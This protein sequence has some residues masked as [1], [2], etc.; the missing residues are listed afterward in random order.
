MVFISLGSPENANAGVAPPNEGKEQGG[1]DHV[2]RGH[3]IND[4]VVS[5]SNDKGARGGKGKGRAVIK[6]K[7]GRLEKQDSNVREQQ[8]SGSMTV[9]VGPSR[10]R[11]VAESDNHANAD[12]APK[13]D[14]VPEPLNPSPARRKQ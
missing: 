12:S 9:M 14:F 10:K 6:D 11:G 8:M 2:I 13:I 4:K 5:N 3:K 1:Q 7:V